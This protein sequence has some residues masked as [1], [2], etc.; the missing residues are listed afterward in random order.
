MKKFIY[1][2]VVF[3]ILVAC[4]NENDAANVSYKVSNAYADTE[5]SYRDCNGITVSNLIEFESGEDVWNYS[6][7]LNRGEIIYLSAVYQDS[8]SSVNLQIIVDGKVYK[9]GS[10]NNQPQKY[11]TISGTIPYN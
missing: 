8:S 6:M 9:Q 10:S 7:K 3:L 2:S 1:I 5:V 4:E 11:I